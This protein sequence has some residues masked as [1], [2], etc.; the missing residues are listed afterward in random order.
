[1]EETNKKEEMMVSDG[2]ICLHPGG[3]HSSTLF[4]DTYAFDIVSRGHPTML[5]TFSFSLF[6]SP[7]VATGNIIRT[8]YFLLLAAFARNSYFARHRKE[9]DQRKKV[10]F[11]VVSS[12][13]V[14]FSQYKK[15]KR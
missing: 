3:L 7:T 10:K 5:R 1:M 12:F 13:F 15:K 14:P 8:Y 4:P 11:V 6:F 2:I 9:A